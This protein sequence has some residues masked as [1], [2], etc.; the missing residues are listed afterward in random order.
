MV[1][2]SLMCEYFGGTLDTVL[3]INEKKILVDYKTS[4]HITY[5]Y[6]MQTAAYRYMLYVSKGIVIDGIIILQLGKESPIYSETY[7]DLTVDEQYNFMENCTRA[8][9]SLVYAYYNTSYVKEESTKLFNT[10]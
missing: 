3:L 1:E 4:N 9:L 2:E 10:I 6:L 7:V 8:F 5:K